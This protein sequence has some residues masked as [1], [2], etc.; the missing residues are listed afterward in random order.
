LG[1]PDDTE[2]E[3]D[4]FL[5]KR[6]RTIGLKKALAKETEQET[7]LVE[8]LTPS[9]LLSMEIEYDWEPWLER[10]NIHLEGELEKTKRDLNLQKKMARHYA[11]RNKIARAKFK[12]GL[13][14][15]QALKE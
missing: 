10:E 2:E 3:E 8:K 12:R 5:K 15:I 11:L 6:P 1:T 4:K 7:A 9:E 13:A 14:K